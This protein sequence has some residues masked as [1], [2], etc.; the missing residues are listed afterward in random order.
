MKFKDMYHRQGVQD[1]FTSE[2]SAVE[3]HFKVTELNH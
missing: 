2:L 3:R 1:I